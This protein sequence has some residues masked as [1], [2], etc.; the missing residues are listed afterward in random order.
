[1]APAY[2]SALQPL[3]T[4]QKAAIRI[5]FNR[6]YNNHT[7]PIFEGLVEGGATRGMT[8]LVY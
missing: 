8:A 4:K 3:I 1:M 6:K 7:E 5:I 2:P